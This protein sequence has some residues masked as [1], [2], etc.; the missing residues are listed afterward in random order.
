[1]I[2]LGYSGDVL[3][4]YVVGTLTYLWKVSGGYLEELMEGKL[5]KHMFEETAEKTVFEQTIAIVKKQ[6]I[7]A[8]QKLTKD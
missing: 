6:Y 4:G 5:F 8:E 1:M 2:F 3:R 7:T